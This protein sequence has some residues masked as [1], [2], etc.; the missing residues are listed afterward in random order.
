[1][2]AWAR[3]VWTEGDE[4]ALKQPTLTWKPACGPYGSRSVRHRAVGLQR[5]SDQWNNC[6]HVQRRATPCL[7]VLLGAMRG[8][9]IECF[10]T[11][12]RHYASRVSH[13]CYNTKVPSTGLSRSNCC[14]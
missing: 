9:P 10:A 5:C 8:T 7:P 4:E 12:C 13:V 6:F 14:P 3:R 11:P 2:E 1:M